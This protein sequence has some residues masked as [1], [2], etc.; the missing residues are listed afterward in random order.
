MLIFSFYKFKQRLLWRCKAIGKHCLIVDERFTS[1]TCTACGNQDYD[2]GGSEMY[3]CKHC[4][5]SID[6]DV[7]GARNIFMKNLNIGRDADVQR[8]VTT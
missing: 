2:L 4:G 7:N 8:E 5:I 3:D 6:R 1:M